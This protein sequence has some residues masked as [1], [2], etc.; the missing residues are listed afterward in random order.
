MNEKC[1][2]T[3]KDSLRNLLMQ[4]DMLRQKDTQAGRSRLELCGQF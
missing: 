3:W 2:A 1:D 4:L